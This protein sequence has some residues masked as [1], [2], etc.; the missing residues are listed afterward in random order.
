MTDTFVEADV[1]KVKLGGEAGDSRLNVAHELDD[2]VWI[3]AKSRVSRVTHSH[4][5]DGRLVRVETTS[6]VEAYLID[7]E[8]GFD[9][10][11]LL[12]RARHEREQAL[13]A[14]LGRQSLFDEEDD[15]DPV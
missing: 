1:V 11:D 14:L 5:T 13:D 7:G 9:I 10:A 8:E 4:D 3:I 2:E 6:P 12:Q 15:D